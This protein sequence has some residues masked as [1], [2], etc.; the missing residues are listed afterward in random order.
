M[1]TILK[2]KCYAERVSGDVVMYARDGPDMNESVVVRNLYPGIKYSVFG[3]A[4]EQN[5]RRIISRFVALCN[6]SRIVMTYGES[7]FNG[8][9]EEMEK[10]VSNLFEVE[11]LDVIGLEVYEDLL[12][13]SV[14]IDKKIKVSKTNLKF[15]G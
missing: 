13:N 11:P 10:D 15:L 9:M 4:G 3:F 8:L 14:N 7:E 12:G 5:A 1:D 2:T 6:S